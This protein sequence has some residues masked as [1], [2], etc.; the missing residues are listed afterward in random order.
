MTNIKNFCKNKSLCVSC[1]AW[2]IGLKF[3]QNFIFYQN[4]DEIHH[5]HV[6]SS[7]QWN[8]C[9]SSK[10]I[11]WCQKII[12]FSIS[13]SAKIMHI[14]FVIFFAS[15]FGWFLAIWLIISASETGENMRKRFSEHVSSSI[16][17][18]EVFLSFLEFCASY[19]AFLQF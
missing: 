1:W 10:F 13:R 3:L 9:C 7:N 2:P 4:L 12:F 17:D 6:K 16:I 19:F 18:L 11:N 14:F 8:I 15:L 5:R